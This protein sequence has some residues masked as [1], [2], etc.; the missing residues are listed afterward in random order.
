[1]LPSDRGGVAPRRFADHEAAVVELWTHG[2][3]DR[4]GLRDVEQIAGPVH[5]D[6][7]VQVFKSIVDPELLP[8]RPRPLDAVHDVA[9]SEDELRLRGLL[10]QREE[11]VAELSLSPERL[12][13]DEDEVGRQ[14][15]GDLLQDARS[16]APKA[17]A[18]LEFLRIGRTVSLVPMI[19]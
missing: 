4:I 12:V 8:R 2:R 9:E 5:R 14:A 6:P 1:M 18:G 7:I 19:R 16:D 15:Q 17:V 11:A 10:L 3:R 13:V